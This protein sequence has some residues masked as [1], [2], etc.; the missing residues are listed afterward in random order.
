MRK[1]FA[2]RTSQDRTLGSRVS[3]H[4]NPIELIATVAEWNDG[5]LTIHEG[6]QNAEAIR[7]GLVPRSD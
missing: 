2:D 7:H 4:Q 1:S 3:Q 6:T 5:K